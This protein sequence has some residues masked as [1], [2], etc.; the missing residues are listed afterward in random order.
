MVEQ[1]AAAICGQRAALQAATQPSLIFSV[2]QARQEAGLLTR[3]LSPAILTE[4]T[5]GRISA[6]LTRKEARTRQRTTLH[7]T[8]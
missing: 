7:S 2:R 4:A 8:T 1:T 3:Q 6:R 5:T